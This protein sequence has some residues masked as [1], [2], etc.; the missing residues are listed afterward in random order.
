VATHPETHGR[1]GLSDQ[2]SIGC[3][4]VRWWTTCRDENLQSWVTEGVPV[5]NLNEQA[6]V[7]HPQQAGSGFKS[8][9]AGKQSAWCLP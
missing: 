6:T 9:A 5:A 4:R 1:N 8:R 7:R 2:S 3:R